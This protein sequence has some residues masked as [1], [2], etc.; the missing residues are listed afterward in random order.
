MV[1]AGIDHQYY[2][3]REEDDVADIAVS[4][5]IISMIPMVFILSAHPLSILD[6]NGR[7]QTQHLS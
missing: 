3:P 6:E 7:R 2:C 1:A 4:G 5:Y